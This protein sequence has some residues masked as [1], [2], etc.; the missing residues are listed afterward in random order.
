[1]GRTQKRR[2]VNAVFEEQR[3]YVAGIDLAGHADHYVCG[4][5]RVQ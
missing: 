4:P 1:M 3:R 2:E 5:R